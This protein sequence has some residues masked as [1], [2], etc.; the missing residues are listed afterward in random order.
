MK[1]SILFSLFS[2]ACVGVSTFDDLGVL[3]QSVFYILAAIFC[4]TGAILFAVS[5]KK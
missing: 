5:S 2:V 1:L 3:G 4:T